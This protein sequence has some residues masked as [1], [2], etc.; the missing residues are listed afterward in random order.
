[1]IYGKL[2][3]DT[4]ATINTVN[5]VSSVGTKQLC[6]SGLKERQRGTREKER[7]RERLRVP[8]SKNHDGK[9]V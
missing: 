5:H 6:C 3:G 9:C 8:M 1:M 7:E 2:A 4:M